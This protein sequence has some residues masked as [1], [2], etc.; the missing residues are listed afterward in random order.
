MSAIRTSSSGFTGRRCCF[1]RRSPTAPICPWR[2]WSAAEILGHRD[3]YLPASLFQGQAEGIRLDAHV[4]PLDPEPIL[5]AAYA[6]PEGSSRLRPGLRDSR[7]VWRR[8]GRHGRG[9]R[10]YRPADQVLGRGIS[11]M[12]GLGKFFAFVKTP[13][14]LVCCI[15]LPLG[16][17]L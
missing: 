7:R 13:L 9:R 12:P 6:G 3:G 5:P 14:G 11:S 4:N 2:S 17:L 10:D 8:R 1:P 15:A 16:I